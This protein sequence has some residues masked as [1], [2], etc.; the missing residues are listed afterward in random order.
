MSE[1]DGYEVNEYGLDILWW[2]EEEKANE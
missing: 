2:W 1:L